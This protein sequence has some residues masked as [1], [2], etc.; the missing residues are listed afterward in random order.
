MVAGGC[1]RRGMTFPEMSLTETVVHVFRA[2]YRQ[3]ESHDTVRHKFG[4]V[5]HRYVLLFSPRG[6]A[7]A[8]NNYS[9]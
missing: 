3:I 8:G 2:P 7:E 1:Q 9:S 4:I 6:R 5:W